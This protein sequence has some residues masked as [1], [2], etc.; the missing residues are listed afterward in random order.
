MMLGI[1]GWIFFW[2]HCE[3]RCFYKYENKDGSITSREGS[4]ADVRTWE[5]GLPFQSLREECF[6]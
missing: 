4:L 2:K 1:N 5:R 3:E 6:I